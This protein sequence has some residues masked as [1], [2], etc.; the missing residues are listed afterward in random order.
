MNKIKRAAVLVHYDRNDMVDP[1]VYTY[2]KALK[3][4]T[5]HLVFV[6]TAKLDMKQLED[7]KL[8]C[9]KVIVRE[10]IGY[11]FMSY[12]IGLESFDYTSYDE[13]LLCN[14]SV[15][16]PFYP[17]TQLFDSM[18]SMKCDFWG[19]T[20]NSVMG[21]HLQSYFMLFKHPVLTSSTFKNFWKS[22]KVLPHKSDIIKFYEVGL[23]KHLMNAGYVPTISTSFKPTFFNNLKIVIL[24]LTPKKII[25]KASS[26]LRKKDTLSNIGKNNSTHYFWKELLVE[27]NMPFVKIELLRDNPMQIDIQN[28]YTIIN[29][30]STYDTTLIKNHLARMKGLSNDT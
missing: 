17:M 19:I 21:Y 6:S 20:D 15:Y 4:C 1:Y 7:L 8:I 10:N 9:E 12:K 22:V 16:G 2:L 13:V 24:K 25:K 11:D 23:T 27:D 28:I 30:I 26:L 18:Q 29:K 3:P 5:S 14:D